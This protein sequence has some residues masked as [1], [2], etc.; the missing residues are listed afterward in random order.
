LTEH[1]LGLFRLYLD[2]LWLWNER[3]NLTGLTSRDSV[4][5][6][7]FLDSLMPGPF[8][9]EEGSLLDM[10]SGGGFPG[11][12]LKIYKPRLSVHLLEANSK[13]ASFLKQVIRLLDLKDIQVIRG[14]IEDR[15][16]N[17]AHDRYDVVTAR[18]LA[19]SVQTMRWCAPFLSHHGYLVTFL[20]SHPEKE[21]SACGEAMKIHSL[22][23]W[24]TITYLL[25]R[26]S[27]KRNTVILRKK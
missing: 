22:S 4:I 24:K 26:K 17:Q 5:T 2:E 20:G 18:A 21:L 27:K 3:V 23:V 13:R 19:G 25:P 8:L 7:L 15:L 6:E 1:H 11:V 14:R 10:G 16:D 12:P 9:P